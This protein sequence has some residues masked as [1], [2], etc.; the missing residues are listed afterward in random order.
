[1]TTQTLEQPLGPRNQKTFKIKLNPPDQKSSKLLDASTKNI[2]FSQEDED[3]LINIFNSLDKKMHNL[4]VDLDKE[5][6]QRKVVEI[7]LQERND[8]CDTLYNKVTMY[9]V[10]NKEKVSR[11]NEIMKY[12]ENIGKG[13]PEEIKRKHEQNAAKW[14]EDYRKAQANK[15]K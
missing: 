2:N 9:E 10:K 7:A 6:Q 3:E 14:L 5:K 8:E 1:M 13:L 12:V 11:V 15:R 4:Q